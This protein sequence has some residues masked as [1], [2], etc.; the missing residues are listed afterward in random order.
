MFVCLLDIRVQMI[1]APGTHVVKLAITAFEA[2]GWQVLRILFIFRVLYVN[3]EYFI[4]E[5]ISCEIV[6]LAASW[7]ECEV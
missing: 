1:N 4:R 7:I 5:I 3:I 2:Y 6:D